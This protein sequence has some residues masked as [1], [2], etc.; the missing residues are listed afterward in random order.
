LC[1]IYLQHAPKQL[2]RVT[3][4][5]G[6]SARHMAQHESEGGRTRARGCVRNRDRRR[7]RTDRTLDHLALSLSPP[8]SAVLGGTATLTG[9]REPDE[10]RAALPPRPP[11]RRT[12]RATLSPG[13]WSAHCHRLDVHD[14]GRKTMG[15]YDIVFCAGSADHA[16]A[17][18]WP[19]R[20]SMGEL[21]TARPAPGF[22]RRHLAT[23][24]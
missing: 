4:R 1:R 5:H 13:R 2:R 15:T 14:L 10:R 22:A 9:C 17:A 18:V 3:R 24:S 6:G 21:A 11:R 16:S 7:F 19:H 12:T 23:A 20:A 8:P